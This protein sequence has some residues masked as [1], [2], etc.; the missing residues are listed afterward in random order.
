MQCCRQGK[1][2]Q[3]HVKTDGEVL[4]LRSG[5]GCR[6]KKPFISHPVLPD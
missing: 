4:N 2:L 3:N 1:C 6:L 5:T